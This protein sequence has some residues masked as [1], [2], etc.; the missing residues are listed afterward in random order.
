[1]F[2]TTLAPAEQLGSLADSLRGCG[3]SRSRRAGP[4]IPRPFAEAN[5]PSRVFAKKSIKDVADHF[6]AVIGLDREAGRS[7]GHSSAG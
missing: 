4:T 3:Y 7:S 6:D 5:A 1:V 2:T